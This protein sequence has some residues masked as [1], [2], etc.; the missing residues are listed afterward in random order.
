MNKE[1]FF[2][3]IENTRDC[4]TAILD[5]AVTKGIFKAKRD[6]LDMRKMIMFGAAC[7][8]VLAMCFT[9]NMDIFQTLTERYFRNWHYTMPG[10]SDALNNYIENM[11]INAEKNF[12]GL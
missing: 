10:A 12:G 6:V 9:V 1:S 5:D 3:Y 11:I 4:K 7:L 2:R 8:F